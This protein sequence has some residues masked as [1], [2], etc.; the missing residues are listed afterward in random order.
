[1]NKGNKQLIR[2]DG[3]NIFFEVM[4]NAFNISKVLINFIQYDTSKPQKNRI[5]NKISIYLDF[6]DA[7]LLANDILTGKIGKLALNEKKT[8]KAENKKY[9][10][11]IWTNMGGVSAKKLE[12]RNQKRS[13]G[14]SLSRCLKIIPGNKLPF[15]FQAECGKG[16]ESE[17]GLIVPKY[18]VNPDV[19]LMVGLDNDTIKKFAL[20]VQSHIIAYFASQYSLAK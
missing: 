1:M 18:G 13:D 16:E 19:K 5:V 12:E 8:C 2:I 6:E 10:S 9:C 4:G 17:T 7:L 11:P 20:I 14:M 15:I 3:R